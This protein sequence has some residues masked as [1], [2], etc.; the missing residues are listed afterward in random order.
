MPRISD[1]RRLENELASTIEEV[2]LVML[3]D[4]D[5]EP[6]EDSDYNDL[7]STLAPHDTI[8]DSRYLYRG[9]QG[10][11]GQLPIEEAIAEYLK[12]PYQSF[13][14]DFLTKRAFG[15]LQTF[16]I[17]EKTSFFTLLTYRLLTSQL[18]VVFLHPSDE[19][20]KFFNLPRSRVDGAEHAQG[21]RAGQALV[22]G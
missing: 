18:L 17:S 7:L 3:L 9:T 19:V 5:S 6:E 20:F 10:F 14:A 2:A 8:S 4:S 16:S 15:F 1:K 13:L 21:V 22:E 11:S 12:Y